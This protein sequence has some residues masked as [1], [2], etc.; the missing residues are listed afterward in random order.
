MT[1]VRR[2]DKQQ[3][4][5]HKARLV[6]LA[7]LV[8][9][10]VSSDY[11]DWRFANMPDLRTFVIE[12]DGEWVAF[13]MGYGISNNRYY[14]WFG[15]VDPDHRG[16]GYAE[17]LMQAQHDW[18]RDLGYPV[19]ET[20]VRQANLPMVRLNQKYGFKIVGRLTKDSFVSLVMQAGLR[21]DGKDL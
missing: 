14:S 7:R 9:N 20:H 4:I 21:S 13:K 3:S 5:K 6:T 11:F 2:L 8:F 16:Q 18:V 15:G 10:D 12:H 19:V 17:Q 1:Q